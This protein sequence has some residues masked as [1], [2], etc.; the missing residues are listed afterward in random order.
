VLHAR[1]ID[2]PEKVRAE[3]TG[4]T[5]LDRLDLWVLQAATAQSIEDLDL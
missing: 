2:V 4:C 1:G 5:D 3:I